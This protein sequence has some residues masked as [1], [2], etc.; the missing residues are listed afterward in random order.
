MAESAFVSGDIEYSL[1]FEKIL[2]E[3]AGRRHNP[4]QQGWALFGVASI[5]IRRGK[6][7][8]AIP[9]LEEALQILEE[10]PNLASS[11][12]T[13][14]QLAL[15]HFRLGNE[16]KAL[17]YGSTVINLAADITPTVYS[18]HI[19]LSA[20]AQVYFELW[21]RA[22]QNPTGKVGA[23]IYKDH[24]EEAI[25]LLRNFRKMV[26][27]GQPYLSYFEGWRQW[28]MGKHEKAIQTWYKGLEAARKYRTLY[29][30][31][32]LRAKLGVA[33]KDAPE[34]RREHFERAKQIFEEMGAVRELGSLEI[35]EVQ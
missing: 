22:L 6:E 25:R 15:A 30:E 19:G 32:L 24:A 18:L 23:Y 34:Q 20:I 31:G 29:E 13:N 27:I 26:P 28:L 14:G 21:E 4:L 12:N 3:D 9:M 1:K 7:A 2:L 16:A 8:I 33:L 10:L 5:S 35:P 11:I 17:E